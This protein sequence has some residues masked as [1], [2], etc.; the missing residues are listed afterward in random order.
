MSPQVFPI[1][2][3]VKENLTS[4]HNTGYLVGYSVRLCAIVSAGV[5][6]VSFLREFRGMASEVCREVGRAL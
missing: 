3:I 1:T 5:F 6:A 2:V 4:L